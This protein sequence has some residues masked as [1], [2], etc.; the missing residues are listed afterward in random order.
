[1]NSHFFTDRFLQ[2]ILKLPHLPWA[3]NTLGVLHNI[4]YKSE[5]GH[6]EAD[7]FWGGR[8]VHFSEI[9]LQ[10]YLPA[11]PPDTMKCILFKTSRF[12]FERLGTPLKYLNTVC[13]S[14]LVSQVFYLICYT[15]CLP[16]H[17]LYQQTSCE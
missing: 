15:I 5:M 7:F 9:I 3:H 16:L 14:N 10:L 13:H 1:M 11:S 12:K 2:F 8:R 6:L 4:T 17:S